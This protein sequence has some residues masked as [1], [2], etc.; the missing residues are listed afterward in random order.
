[1]LDAQPD[2]KISDLEF[3]KTAF[4]DILKMGD[5]VGAFENEPANVNAYLEA[6]KNAVAVFVDT[7]SSQDIA[8]PDAAIKVRSEVRWIKT[9][10]TPTP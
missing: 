9:F 5:V 4:A 1:L 7:R 2:R 8:Q 6:F 10:Y 3:K